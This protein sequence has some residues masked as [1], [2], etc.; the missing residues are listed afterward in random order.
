MVNGTIFLLFKTSQG[1]DSLG[2]RTPR[3]GSEPLASAP[4]MHVRG[5]KTGNTA[6]VADERDHSRGKGFTARVDILGGPL[7]IVF[8]KLL[9]L[10]L[11]GPRHSM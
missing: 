5:R 3:H 10:T 7:V 9:F 2:T 4:P 6:G 8:P 1:F 11:V